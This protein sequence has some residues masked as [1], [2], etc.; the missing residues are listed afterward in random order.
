MPATIDDKR[1]KRLPWRRRGLL[2][3]VNGLLVGAV[4]A[5]PWADGLHRLGIDFLLPVRHLLYGPMYPAARSNAVVVSIDEETYRTPPFSETPRVAWT[6]MLAKVVAAVDRAGPRVIGLDMIFPTSLDRP[7]LL[8]GY[9]KPLLRVLFEAGRA[10]RMVLGNVRL[11]QQTID[12]YKGLRLAVGGAANIRPLN[13]LLDADNVVRRY[14]A[15]FPD[16][17][18]GAIPSFAAELARRAGAKVGS[19]F[20]INYNTG[21]NDIPA[22]SFADLYACV[23][24]G[25][26]DYFR[27]HFAGK[28]VI[29]GAALDVEDRRF[30]AKRFAVA[31]GGS[32]PSARCRIAA[33]ASRF[34][35]IVSR[36]SIPGALIH[37]AAVNTLI[38]G[39]ALTLLDRAATFAVTAAGSAGLAVVFF[40]LAPASGLLAALAVLAAEGGVAAVAFRHGTVVP[41]TVLGLAAAYVFALVYAYRFVVED[42]MK[43]R[44]KHAFGRYLAP[45]LVERLA[46]GEEPLRLGGESRRVTIMFTDIA[47]Y[48]T[49][50]EGLRK[51]PEQLVDVL[52][53]YFTVLTGIV[54]RHQGYVVSF[55]GDAIMALWGAP[56]GDPH[57]ER[58]AVA[59]ALEA[60]AALE[61]FN[62]QVVQGE[63]GLDAI[64]TR[65][66]VNTGPAVVG[67][68]GS[69]N[70]L[71]YTATGDTTNLAARLESA[72]KLY[73]T[74]LIVSAETAGG[75]DGA[76][77]RRRV[78]KLVVKGKSEPI[79]VFEVIGYRD[80]VRAERLARIAEFE[81]A[82]DL[83]GKRQFAAAKAAFE[84]LAVDDAAAKLY[85]DRCH[86]YESAPP[87]DDWDGSFVAKTK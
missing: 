60:M 77:V 74:R 6:P 33:D 55:M 43:R 19:D 78:D 52:N 16:E 63:F 64:G 1:P 79:D 47:G 28:V 3:V 84:R 40:L 86:H 62:A 48:T 4:A 37:A 75:L 72:N 71:N 29:V 76:F 45:T 81:S 9:D 65:F 56:A 51:K 73:G 82:L 25:D 54:E 35:E 15:A 30:P 70:R 10:G 58:N 50:S 46:E 23:E 27:R 5:G 8:P 42:R 7:E 61:E 11:S 59:A 26:I 87:P 32:P 12:P 53:R 69:A 66:G 85:V 83:Y 13:L 39:D 38:R 31:G 67:N 68:T 44:I 24:A 34:G 14:P 36:Q 80:R 41:V 18:G 22:Y 17:G 49:L 20:L 2:A 21:A 57:A